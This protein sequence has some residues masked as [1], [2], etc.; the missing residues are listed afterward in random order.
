MEIRIIRDKRDLGYKGKIKD[1]MRSIG[2]GKFVIVV[3]SD[4][5]LK[6]ENCMFELLEIAQQGDFHRRIFPIVLADAN[7]YKAINRLKYIEYW[8]TQIAELDA[9]MKKV[10]GA[11]YQASVTT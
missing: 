9:A 6:S 5:Y 3:I 10:G 4:K 7:V 11:N 1:F 2:K 8:E